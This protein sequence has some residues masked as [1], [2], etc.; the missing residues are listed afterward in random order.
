MGN[1]FSQYFRCLVSNLITTDTAQARCAGHTVGLRGGV[2]GICR[3]SQRTRPLPPSLYP[4]G[5]TQPPSRTQS[6]HASPAPRRGAGSKGTAGLLPR[7]QPCAYASRLQRALGAREWRRSSGR[8]GVAELQ[9][10]GRGKGKSPCRGTLPASGLRL[11]Q[12]KEGKERESYKHFQMKHTHTKSYPTSRGSGS[13]R[14]HFKHQ[15]ENSE[16]ARER[17]AGAAGPRR[18]RSSLS[19]QAAPTHKAGG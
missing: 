11:P 4:N 13:G 8:A 7:Q 17:P 5:G 1:Q 14:T 18:D 3:N 10:P 12:P 6:P 19:T 9:P 15:S 2:T 16:S